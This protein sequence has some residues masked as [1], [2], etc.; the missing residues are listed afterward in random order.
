MIREQV[1]K[2]G[3]L[4]ESLRGF[5]R[6]ILAHKAYIPTSIDEDEVALPILLQFELLDELSLRIELGVCQTNKTLHLSMQLEASLLGD[7]ISKLRELA[8]LLAF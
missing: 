1:P 3:L 2:D 7:Q 6:S 8:I 4:V 5:R